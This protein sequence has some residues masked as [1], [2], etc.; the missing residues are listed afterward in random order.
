MRP[1]QRPAN[2]ALDRYA[3]LASMGVSSSARRFV[4]HDARSH[5][6]MSHFMQRLH[7]RRR[8]NSYMLL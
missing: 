1:Q 2:C 8:P 4:A 6:A 7:R 5:A 3:T